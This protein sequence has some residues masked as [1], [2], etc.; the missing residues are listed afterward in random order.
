M[1]IRMSICMS[2]YMYACHTF[3]VT[4]LELYCSCPAPA[5][6]ARLCIWPCF[7][8][9]RQL[10]AGLAV[11]QRPMIQTDMQMDMQIDGWTGYLPFDQQVIVLSGSLV[12]IG[13]FNQH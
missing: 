7:H 2:V 12:Q 3:L 13:N 11:T 8:H 10:V 5:T 1:S 4:V 9:L 6:D